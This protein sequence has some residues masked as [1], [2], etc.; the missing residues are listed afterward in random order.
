MQRWISV[1]LLAALTSCAVRMPSLPLGRFEAGDIGAMAD[2][3]I[4]A[5]DGGAAENRALALNVLGECQLL[6]GDLEGAAASFDE[7]GRIMGNWSVSGSEEFAAIVGAEGSSNYRGDPYEKAMNAFYLGMTYLWRGEADNARAAFKRGLLADGESTE[8]EYRVDFTLLLWLA[9]RMSNLMGLPQDAEDFFREAEQANA[10]CIEHG[11]QGSR[12][13]AVLADPASGNVVLLFGIGSAPKKFAA[14]EDRQLARFRSRAHSAVRARVAVDGREAGRSWLMTDVGYQARTRGGT[15]MEG[16][17]EG[18][19]VFKRAAGIAG[20]VTLWSAVNED[21]DAKRRDKLI[22]GGA[23]LIL[24][25]LTRSEADTRHWPTLPA[26]IHA[27]TLDLAPGE[28][29]IVV[30]FLDAKGQT[31]K[32]YS[33]RWTVQVPDAGESYYIFRSIPGLDRLAQVTT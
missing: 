8:D 21:S 3:A 14:G 12:D 33:Q 29:E 7:A 2:A 9:G 28:H 25:A 13:N 30:E 27:L 18:K 22:V 1:C 31:L 20:E 5:R 10:F 11:S 23:L 24:S 17:R 32:A 16:I 26:S 15:A 6:Q 4:A 19:A